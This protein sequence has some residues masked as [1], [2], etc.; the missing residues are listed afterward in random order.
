M[1]FALGL[2]GG[3]FIFSFKLCL[4]THPGYTFLLD[5]LECI[6][7]WQTTVTLKGSE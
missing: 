3:V 7:F 6:L 5:T 1:T 4:L 2:G